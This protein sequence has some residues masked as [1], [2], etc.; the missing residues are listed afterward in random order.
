M[1]EEAIDSL[2]SIK[3]PPT[4]PAIGLNA[5][6]LQKYLHRRYLTVALALE[7]WKAKWTRVKAAH[8]G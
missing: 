3:T 8:T 1:L 2:K 4:N 7:G 5:I 6:L